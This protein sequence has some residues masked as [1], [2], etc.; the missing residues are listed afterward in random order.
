[1][2]Y[3]WTD[4]DNKIIL[5]LVTVSAITCV[6]PVFLFAASFFPCMFL[7]VCAKRFNMPESVCCILGLLIPKRNTSNVLQL[8]S[9]YF[10]ILY[11]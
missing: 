7:R 9:N 3:K 8:T 6:S 5:I 2:I 10:C 1:M 11:R 4:D